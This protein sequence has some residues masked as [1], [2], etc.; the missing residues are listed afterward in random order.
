MNKQYP[1][2]RGTTVVIKHD[3]TRHIGHNGGRTSAGIKVMRKCPASPSFIMHV[4]GP[5]GP[6]R[7]NSEL[8]G[9]AALAPLR[10]SHNG[11]ATCRVLHGN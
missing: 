4:K 2:E 6:A 10:Y 7:G 9:E 8:P 11:F 5:S 3:I 1:G